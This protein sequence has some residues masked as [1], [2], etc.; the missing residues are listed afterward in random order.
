MG[1]WGKL[2]GGA[3]GFMVGGPI[4]ALIGAALGHGIDRGAE[5]HAG[6][7]AEGLFSRQERA[8]AV[9]FTATFSVMG[10]LAK[11]DGR[12]T[13]DEIEVARAVMDRLGLDAR[14]RELAQHLFREGKDPDFPLDAVLEQLR[15]ECRY[16]AN[17]LRVFLEIQLHA[18]WADGA[19]HPA[20]RA[21]L[22]RICERLGFS[23]AE[24]ARLEA[25]V[26]GAPARP[27]EMPLERAYE[28]L[29]LE[30]GASAAEV[31]RAY[32]RQM[33]RHHPDKLV[34]RGLP[35]EMIAVATERTQQIRAAYERIRREDAAAARPG[36]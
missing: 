35:E 26:R 12:V 5:Q 36:P 22:E 1:W 27:E 18:A 19:V 21:V 2:L 24:L 14:H 7:G 23:A 4:G 31:K 25:M 15:R 10:H 16:S 17:L 9:F 20:E 3:F 29:G 30:P 28:L 6:P 8:Q 32:R 33:S 13:R 34:S 11:A